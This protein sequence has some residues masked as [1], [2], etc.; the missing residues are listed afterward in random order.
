MYKILLNN[1]QKFEALLEFIMHKLE[2]FTDGKITKK[3][4]M[5][6]ILENL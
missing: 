5:C 4:T 2:C 3:V 1:H 6:I